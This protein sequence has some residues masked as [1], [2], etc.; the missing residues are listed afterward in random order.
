MSKVQ[1]HSSRSLPLSI[2]KPRGP[3]GSVLPQVHLAALR[4][5]EWRTAVHL[6]H[7]DHLA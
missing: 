6:E 5:A 2:G 7:S 4:E 3:V 1:K